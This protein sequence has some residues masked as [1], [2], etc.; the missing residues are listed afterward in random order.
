MRSTP[1][2]DAW[3]QHPSPRMLQHSMFQSLVRWMKMEDIPESVPIE[4][5]VGALDAAGIHQAMVCAWSSPQGF[6]ITNDEVAEFVK[7]APDKLVG[8]AAVDISKPMEAVRELRRCVQELGFKAL[9]LLPWL[10]ELPS[11]VYERTA[12]RLPPSI[13]PLLR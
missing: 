9:R 13:A 10:W 11:G 1:I 12:P 2:I 4:L 3:I 7:S 8:V 5:T 6:M